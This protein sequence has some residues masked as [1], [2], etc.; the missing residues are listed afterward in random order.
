M[1]DAV[2]PFLGRL[3]V[4]QQKL[5]TGGASGA[6]ELGAA[7]GRCRAARFATDQDG[8]PSMD[9]TSRW[10]QRPP[11]TLMM[12]AATSISTSALDATPAPGAL[13]DLSR[14]L[15]EVG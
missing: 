14:C 9:G 4:D 15:L 13:A 3:N 10:A 7:D 12:S 11:D 1:F 2:V 8:R 5:G 6:G